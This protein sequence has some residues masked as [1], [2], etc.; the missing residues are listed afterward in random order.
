MLCVKAKYILDNKN[1]IGN[2]KTRN[3]ILSWWW[4]KFGLLNKFFAHPWKN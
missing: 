3:V 1:S 4:E 2:E